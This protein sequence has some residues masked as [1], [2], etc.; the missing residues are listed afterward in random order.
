MAMVKPLHLTPR[1]LE[2][3]GNEPKPIWMNGIILVLTLSFISF[4]TYVVLR[5]ALEHRGTSLGSWQEAASHAPPINGRS[6]SPYGLFVNEGPALALPS[7]RTTSEEESGI[8]RKFYG[9]QGDKAHLGGFT[10]FDPHGVSPTLW[11]HMVNHL[12][13]KTL[14]DVVRKRP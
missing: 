8:D 1:P 14:L 2:R 11:K 9:G 13:I 6:S 7:I 12:G 3:H 10:S 4:N 5:L